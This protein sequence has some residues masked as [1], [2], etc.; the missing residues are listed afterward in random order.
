MPG[1]RH[2]RLAAVIGRSSDQGC[3]W[4]LRT[5]RM[6]PHDIGF[7]R[8]LMGDNEA[9][10]EQE[11]AATA[12]L[13]DLARAS[14]ATRAAASTCSRR[15]GLQPASASRRSGVRRAGRRGSAFNHGA[16]FGRSTASRTGMFVGLAF[17]RDIG[18]WWSPQCRR[19][20]STAPRL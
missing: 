10:T 3:D 19:G 14:P 1:A 20:C 12:L 17:D 11:K 15:F 4:N 7:D 16:G 6:T 18:L 13:Q 5:L 9:I 8:Y 2:N